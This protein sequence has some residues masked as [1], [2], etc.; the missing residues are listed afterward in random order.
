M[1]DDVMLLGGIYGIAAYEDDQWYVIANF[2]E[3]RALVEKE[4][5]LK[6]IQVIN[7]VSSRKEQRNFVCLL[8]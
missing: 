5:K 1:T 2:P 3:F 8:L 4:K 7:L 6:N